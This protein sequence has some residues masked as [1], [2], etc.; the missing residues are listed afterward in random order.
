MRVSRLLTVFVLY[1]CFSSYPQT[2]G[3]GDW[4][5]DYPGYPSMRE[6]RVLVLTNTC[7]MAPVE[8]RDTY[9]GNYTILLP[10][11]YPPVDPLYWYIDLNRASRFHSKDMADNHGLD[12]S[13]SDGTAWDDRIRS[14]YTKSGWFAEN[15][16]TGGRDAFSS[17]KQWIMDGDPPAP[18]G[19]GD[20]HRKSIMG[21]SYNEL[22]VGY[23]YGDQK[24]NYFWTQDFSTGKPDYSTP[25]T[26]GAHFVESDST[27]FMATYADPQGQ[28]PKAASIV[29]DGA[30]YALSL[31]MGEQEN[32][33]FF[34]G[35][36]SADDCRYYYFQF[37]DSENNLW[38]HPEGGMLVTLGEGTCDKEYQD[39]TNGILW[40]PFHTSNGKIRIKK[41]T[42]YEIVLEITDLINIPEYSVLMNCKGRI[43]QEQKWED[44][45][46]RL[47]L[48]PSIAQ[49]AYF[50]IHH[51]T[52]QT[53][54]LT[55]VY[56]L[57]L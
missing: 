25:I 52:N 2:K 13:S 40:Q 46:L 26:S 45:E 53:R 1:V 32:G 6:R 49:G 7:R 16:A 4:P 22:G 56:L 35:T 17:M 55:K 28:T 18:D 33:A 23:A 9:I 19:S 42:R 5:D 14:F 37:S 12:H 50:L 43:L 57:N 10:Q 27:F 24:W 51:F 15:I 36:P 20:G 38:R 11:N 34:L 21:S 48:N 47:H 8:Y 54:M 39:P 29:I 41:I 44:K 3:Y 30:V 31:H